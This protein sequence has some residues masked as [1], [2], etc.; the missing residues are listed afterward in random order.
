VTASR[1]LAHSLRSIMRNRVRSLLTSLGII[2]G[3]GS[4]IVMV[5]V[6]EGSQEQISR[7]ISSM[8]TNLIIVVP[9]RG[10]NQANRITRADVA[11]LKA[12]VGTVNAVSGEV[13]ISTK[14]VGGS[15]YRSTTVNGVEPDFLSIR[16]WSVKEGEFFT[17]A[18]LKSR[19][20]VAVV[21]KTVATKLFG[22]TSPI[23]ETIRIQATPFKI[24]GVMEQK[25]SSGMGDDQDD[26]VIVPLDTAVTRLQKDRYLS[27]ILLSASRESLMDAAQKEIE[28]VMRESHRL[29][30]GDTADFDVFNQAEIIKTAS[31][32]SK[33]LTTLL[34]AIAGVSLLVGGIG[35]MNIMLV[36]VTERTR[37][38]GIRMSVGARRRD[39]LLQFLTESVILSL[40]G[41]AIGIGLAVG[42]AW[43]VQSFMGTPAIIKPGIIFESAGFAAAVGIFFGFYPARKAAR[44]Y[45][46]DALRY[47]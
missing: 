32:T 15:G 14:V 26:C 18:D 39:I 27:A 3:V 6:G 40:M 21:G 33:T 16:Q 17:E 28:Q 20:K 9:P 37:E 45:P 22:D 47:E 42:V 34:A 7:Q 10:P 35:I 23:G 8:G 31:Q 44:L 24:I 13:R 2:I 1:L 25:G 19:S 43:F 36:S 38:I 12:E 41:G 11:R 29:S 5:A 4:V 30:A 46:I